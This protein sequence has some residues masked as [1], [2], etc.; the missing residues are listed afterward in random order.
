LNQHIQP[1]TQQITN[2]PTHSTHDK[3]EAFPNK[4]SL[5][6]RIKDRISQG[7]KNEKIKI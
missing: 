1:N 4:I 5:E 6:S 7:N 2:Q 3:N